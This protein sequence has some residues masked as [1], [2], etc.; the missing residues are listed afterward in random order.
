M[1][2]EKRAEKVLI[3][4]VPM[5][6]GAGRRGVD[7]GPSALRIAEL[8]RSIRQLGIEVE[9]AGNISIRIPEELHYGAK[10][11]MY[12]EEIA[13]A[14]ERLATGVERALEEGA[15]PLVLG[16]DHSIE[17]GTVAGSAA[18]SRRHKERLGLIWIDAHSDMNLPDTSPSGNVHGMPLAALMGLGPDELA[19]LG[20]LVPKVESRN[21]VV[22]AARSIDPSETGNIREVGLR[23]ITMSE[24]DNRGLADAMAEAV[25]I[26]CDG[27]GNFHCSL[28]L[29][30]IDPSVAPG[31]GTPVAGGLTY[32]EAHLAMEMVFASGCCRSLGVV[33]LNPVIDSANRTA[34]L[35]VGLVCSALGK[36][37]LA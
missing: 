2:P 14:C 7:M 24:I 19:S 33:E 18:Y 34:R 15:F 23:V 5:D 6:L 8:N 25:E 26:A 16:G 27:T 32:R 20:D 37:I 29:D 10:K 36:K 12:L 1:N 30:A 3:I 17:A 28:D 35:A 22:I 13:G 21:A 4:G 9:D 11:S 31:V